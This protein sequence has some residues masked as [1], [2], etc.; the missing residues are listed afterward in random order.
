MKPT[1]RGV[2]HRDFNVV[3]GWIASPGSGKT[4]AMIRRALELQRQHSAYVVAHDLGWK[5]PDTLHDGTPTRVVRH[6]TTA[7]ALAAIKRSGAGIHAITTPHGATVL[8]FARDLAERS[9]ARHGKVAPPVI[10]FID[11]I[12]AS[13]LA[14][15]KN[16]DEDM[17]MLISDRR[18]AHVGVLWGVQSVRFVNAGL[19][20][21]STAV[22]VSRMEDEFSQKHL[23]DCGLQREFVL[24]LTNSQ[25][26]HFDRC[27]I[28]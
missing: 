1:A 24:S 6:R 3:E 19:I 20:T 21:M 25:K 26:Y 16:V 23:V 9:L 12:V 28:G 7:E 13:R 14:D 18:H 5:L 15:R 10:F 2:K 4:E 11:E 22:S 8:A 17:R 27:E